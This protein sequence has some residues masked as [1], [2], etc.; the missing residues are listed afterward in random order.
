MTN[1]SNI[2]PLKGVVFHFFRIEL[3]FIILVSCRYV[4]LKVSHFSTMKWKY[5]GSLVFLPRTVRFKI[6]I[7]KDFF[8]QESSVNNPTHLCTL[9]YLYR[10]FASFV[11][12]LERIR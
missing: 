2:N 12:T 4:H 10:L 5:N 8:S 3:F 9:L 11:L 1:H 7:L 6:Y